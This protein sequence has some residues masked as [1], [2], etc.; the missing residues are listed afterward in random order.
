MLKVME[1][2]VYEEDPLLNDTLPTPSLNDSFPLLPGN[3]TDTLGALTESTLNGADNLDTNNL[4]N[5]LS[6]F[7]SVGRANKNYFKTV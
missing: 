5:F 6:T 4:D 1:N 7:T 3:T 2:C